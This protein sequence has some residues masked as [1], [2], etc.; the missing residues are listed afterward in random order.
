MDRRIDYYKHILRC[1]YTHS[2]EVDTAAERNEILRWA[3]ALG[4]AIQLLGGT[5][6]DRSQ[7]H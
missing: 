5:S 2:Q 1:M 7:L 4:E 6:N 3:T